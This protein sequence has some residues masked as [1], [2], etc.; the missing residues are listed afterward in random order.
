V[1]CQLSSSAAWACYLRATAIATTRDTEYVDTS[2]PEGPATYRVGIGTNW[3]SDPA[4]GDIFV[5]SPPVVAQD[6]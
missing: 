3:L 2:A 4:L 5:F 1:Q 6:R